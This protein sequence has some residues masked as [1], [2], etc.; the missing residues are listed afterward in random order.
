M[1]PTIRG[2]TTLLNPGPNGSGYTP[3]EQLGE[4]QIKHVLILGVGFLVRAGTDLETACL[5]QAFALE[6][7]HVSH[8]MLRKTACCLLC[9]QVHAF[10]RG[11]GVFVFAILPH[12]EWRIGSQNDVYYVLVQCPGQ[13]TSLPE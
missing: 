2:P 11:P 5:Q 7:G 13:Q 1:G 10:V 12:L 8:K 3:T 4:L 6:H 9:G